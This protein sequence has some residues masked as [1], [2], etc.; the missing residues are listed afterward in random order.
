MK[1]FL[2]IPTAEFVHKRQHGVMEA[3]CNVC[4]AAGPKYISTFYARLCKSH[5]W[6]N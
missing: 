5:V 3:N 6:K 1:H 4:Y 2:Y